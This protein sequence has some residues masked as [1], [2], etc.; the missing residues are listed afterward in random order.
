MSHTQALAGFLAGLS[1]QQLPDSVLARTEELF[2]DWLGSAL[3]S[4]GAH[5][6]PLFER[7]AQQMGPADGPARIL[8]KGRGSSAYFAALVNAA[9]S[10]LVE[11]DDL[12]NS[13]V[14][15]PATVVFPAALAA[16]QDL[17]KSGRELLLAA[18][19]GYEAGI[20]IGEFMGRSHYRI[21]H[22]TATVGTLAAAVAVGKLMD[23]DQA[24][25][26]NLLGSA[27]TQ[28][29]GL[30][31]FLRDAADSKQLHTAKAAADGLLAAY[32]TR[33][34]LTGARNILEGEQG[35][36]A[37]MSWDAEPSRLSDRLGSRWALLETS[38][39]YHASCRHTHPA[40]D[41]LLALMQREVLSHQQIA[42]VETRV[43]QGA[44][45]VLGRVKVPQTVHQ[46]KFSM[47][48]VL[49]LIAVHGKA[50]LP[51]FHELA[52]KDPAVAAFRDKVSMVLDPE[53]DRAY[54]Q[55]WLGRVVVST[56][57]GRTLHGAI[58]EPK[59]D[60]GN[61]LSRAELE[62][63]FQ[64]LLRF[65]GARTPEQGEALIRQ[66]WHLRDT[67]QLNELL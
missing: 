46:A 59:G 6:I 52:L 12:H 4:Q 53:V 56:D 37:G 32:L 13:S 8:V 31:E 38:F 28:A 33:D 61:G 24:Q 36:A 64:R 50:G 2:L 26:I 27:G 15:H 63:K 11:Q 62:D 19:A 14:L 65:S 3:A 55:R 35:M 16:A 25:F 41:A 57:D 40:A 17:G 60:P 48:T 21:F 18:V 20:R 49:G 66:V 47:G 7:Y 30:W 43:H 44:I 54:P 45:D 22:T 29:A 5:P 10:H 51:E 1:Y 9:S 39:K 67:V 58:D 23:F 34:G 42:R